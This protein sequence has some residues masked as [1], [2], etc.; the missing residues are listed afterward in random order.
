MTETD[1]RIDI[2]GG[3]EEITISP[4]APLRL[5]AGGLY[6]FDSTDYD[7]E[8]GAYASDHGGYIKRR[9]FAEREMGITFEITENDRL[10]RRKLLSV[11]NPGRDCEI[12]V[13]LGEVKRRIGVI[14]V[15]RVTFL[16]DSFYDRTVVKVRFLAPDPFFMAEEARHGAFVRHLPLLTFPMN[17]YPKKSLAAGYTVHTDRGN[18]ANEGDVP[19]GVVITVSALGGEVVNPTVTLTAE[20]GTTPFIRT[21]VTL[22][23]GDVMVID[24]RR[25]RKGIR[26][27]GENRLVFDWKSTFFSLSAGDNALTVDADSGKEYM[28]VTYEYVPLYLGM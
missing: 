14:P 17:F 25:R 4:N 13:R 8:T 15:G 16:Q 19:C 9:R 12:T 22:A 1:Y 26:I 5:L 20:D 6:G 2:W 24:T 7:V 27:N 28:A 3:G 11:V 23:D 18:A 10:W 21:S